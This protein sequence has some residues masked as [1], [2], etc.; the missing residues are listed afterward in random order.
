M[1]SIFVDDSMTLFVHVR[2]CKYISEIIVIFHSVSWSA[3]S[4][5]FMFDSAT[6]LF[7][8]MYVGVVF[9]DDV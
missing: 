5:P 4:F 6:F 9:I 8:R 7:S 2:D 1:C 3:Y